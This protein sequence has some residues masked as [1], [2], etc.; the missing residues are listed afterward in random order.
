MQ[1]LVEQEPFDVPDPE[2]D[3]SWPNLA[4]LHR[5]ESLKATINEGGHVPDDQPD[6]RGLEADHVPLV[7]ADAGH[8]LA[9]AEVAHEPAHPEPEVDDDR[10]VEERKEEVEQEQLVCL[11]L[12]EVTASFDQV[13]KETNSSWSRLGREDPLDDGGSREDGVHHLKASKTKWTRHNMVLKT[14]KKYWK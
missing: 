1:A 5:E 14:Q 12:Q 6:D 7:R 3:L 4:G 9:R 10:D 2:D 8:L 11:A 13:F